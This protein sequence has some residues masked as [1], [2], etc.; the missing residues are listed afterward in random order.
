VKPERVELN[1]VREPR[2]LAERVLQ[3]RLRE[4]RGLTQGLQRRDK[5]G[6]HDF[7]I[8]CK[9]LRYALER[10]GALE[11]SLAEIAERLARLQDALGEAHDRDVL[12]AILPPAMAATERRLRTEREECVDR[13]GA[14][15]SELDEM[16]KRSILTA[17]Q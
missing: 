2:E 17:S 16:I 14:L 15:W 6:L 10:F 3:T 12:L 13:A 8:A 11:P 9:R 4:A 7:R 1:G 5:Q